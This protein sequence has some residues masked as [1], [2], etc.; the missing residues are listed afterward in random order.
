MEKTGIIPFTLFSGAGKAAGS[1]FLRVDSLVE[2]TPDFEVWKHGKQYDSLIFQKAYW[3]E[4][5]E[6]F[7]GPKIL[8]LCDPSWV[9]EMVDII[10]TGKLVDAFTCS[11]A[12]LTRLIGSYFPGKIVEY[13][14]DRLD[15]KQYPYP[16]K[17]HQDEA[18]NV[19]WFGFIHNAYSTL[20][21]LHPA[22]K[23]NRL[24]LTII[25][26]EP[27]EEDDEIKALKPEFIKY[28]QS[29]IHHNLRQADIVLN[30]R[31]DKAFFKYKS[32][33]KSIIS[34]KLGIPVAE[35]NADIDRL[36]DPYE[37]NKEIP[38]KQSLVDKD[39]NILQSADQYRSVINRI[40][41][42]KM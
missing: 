15:L 32:N 31:T 42:D 10:E 7:K 8:D 20:A 16:V 17:I 25:A 13:V 11:S 5:M 12:E 37:R 19:T 38:E 9:R 14:P 23:R 26:N 30:P 18:R 35:T 40:K 33:N 27:Y 1:T 34:W 41:M 28:D 6:A 22:L 39:Y 24:K 36:M 21:Q 29:T 2:N 4:M 3:T